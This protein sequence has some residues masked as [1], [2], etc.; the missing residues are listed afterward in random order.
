[1]TKSMNQYMKTWLGIMLIFYTRFSFKSHHA[2][3]QYL[4]D[5][6]FGYFGVLI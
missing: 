5:S 1:M 3:I 4:N 6:F 2:Y